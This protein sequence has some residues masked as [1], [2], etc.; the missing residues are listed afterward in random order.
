VFI[1]PGLN[2]S[3]LAAQISTVVQSLTY[4][5]A[6]VC[7][8]ADLFAVFDL[9]MFAQASYPRAYLHERFSALQQLCQ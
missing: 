9:L 8:Y 3:F 4:F 1:P 7:Q 5:P 2:Q 6:P